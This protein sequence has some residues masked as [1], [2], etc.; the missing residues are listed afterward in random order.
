MIITARCASPNGLYRSFAT[1]VKND[2]FP[3]SH[4]PSRIRRAHESVKRVEFVERMRI[5]GPNAHQQQLATTCAAA[6]TSMIDLLR[7]RVLKLALTGVCQPPIVLIAWVL[8]RLTRSLT[9]RRAGLP[10]LPQ[11]YREQP[12]PAAHNRHTPDAA[13]RG[14]F[15]ARR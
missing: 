4:Q 2:S 15:I 1:H 5:C 8:V 6:N 11:F 10:L 9:H 14:K 12:P 7:T 13:D 3:L